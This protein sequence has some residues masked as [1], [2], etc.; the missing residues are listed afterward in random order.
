MNF[1]LLDPEEFRKFADKSPYK[2]FYQTPEIAKLR[3]SSGWTPYY[4][5]VRNGDKL[6]AASLVVAKPTFLGKST[7]YAPGGPLLD[8][9]DATLTDFFFKNLRKYAKSHNGY[10]LH[11]EPYY[12]LIQRGR[13]GEVVEGGFNHYQAQQNLKNAGFTPLPE[14]DEPKYA[15]AMDLDGRAPDQIFKDMKAN[16]RNR[17]R[18]AEKKGVT[19]RELGREELNIFKQITESTSNRRNFQDKPLSYYEQMYD[20]F[21]E[22][23]E[24]MFILAEADG[25]PMSAAMFMTY[26]DEVIYLFSGSAEEYMKEYGAQCLIQWHM[27]KYAA[28]HGFK[29]YNFYGIQGLPDPKSPGYGIYEF[30]KGFDSTPHAHVTELIGAHEAPVNH[31]FYAL[32]HLL[33]KLRHH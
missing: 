28:E 22:R 10:V 11:I 18:K 26:G 7:Y 6:V 12:E 14:S 2:S 13:H 23:G 27:I 16:T 15:F 17:I 31:T 9:E 25:T 29:R 5:G 21:H 1:E 24:V 8:Y 3:E 33:H 32:H 4:F 30:K 19:I 20:L